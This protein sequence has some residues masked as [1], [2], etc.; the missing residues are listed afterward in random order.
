[1]S[2]EQRVTT[3]FAGLDKI[4][5]SLRIGDNVVW[6]TESVNDYQYFVTPFVHHALANNRQIVYMRFGQH[7]PL[8][9]E[10]APITVHQLDAYRGFEPF[11]TRVHNIITETGPGAFYVFDC[12]S[13]LLLAW[14][15]DAMISNFFQVTCP[16]LFELDTIAYFALI[17]SG[18]SF[19]TIA[20]I[21]QT[22]QLLLDIY[23][24]NGQNYVHPMKVWQRH[25][26]T[27]FLPHLEQDADFVPIANSY[28]ATNLT[29]IYL[30]FAHNARRQLDYW[31]RLFLEA[32]QLVNN[33]SPQQM[34]LRMIDQLCRVMI[35]HD[36]RMLDL[37]RQY[38]S[39][40]DLLDIKSRTIGTGYIG[41]K[42]VGMLLAR[43]ILLQD[44]DFDWQHYFEPH[45]SFF[46]ASDTYFSYIVHNG[47]WKLL[48]RQK[49]TKGY[50][51]IANELQ[52]KLRQGIFPPEVQAK[53]QEMLEH[54][55]QYP[56]IVRSSSLQEDSFGNAFAGKYES[57]FCVNQG[58]PEE[59]YEQFENAV[60]EIYA[61]T[62]SEDALTYRRQRGLDQHQEQMALLV[63]RVSGAY[64]DHYYFPE[65]AGVGVSHNTFVWDKDMDPKAGM[66][67]LVFGLGTRAVDRVEGDYPRIVA[68]DNPLKQPHH[69]FDDL[70]RFSQRDVDLL[71]VNHNTL[72]TMSLLNL[73]NH[74]LNLDME[75]YAVRDHDLTQ[76]LKKRGDKDQVAWLLTF[77]KLFTE[78]HFTEIMQ[79]MLKTLEKTYCY[80]VDIEFTV[81]FSDGETPK[82]N[83]LQCRPLQTRGQERAVQIPED[84]EAE[85]I[86]FSSQGHFMGGNVSQSIQYLIWVDPQE[87]SVLPR[88]DKYEVARLVGHLNKR[89]CNK[90]NNP[91]LL[92]GPGRWG[93]STPSLGIPVRFA[94]INNVTAL[95]EI[96]F[97][98]E[99][100][101]P[102]LSFGTHFFQDLVETEIFYLALFPENPCCQINSDF[103][104]RQ[105]N[106]LKELIPT[107]S[108]FNKVIKVMQLEQELYLMSDVVSQR[109]ICFH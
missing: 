45:D 27:M 58:T 2:L 74:C 54:F 52:E 31:D 73:G 92:M 20:Q 70:R 36:D 99:G 95:V 32:E 7:K 12:L 34:Q 85:R 90:Q 41:G 14:A 75:R 8:I 13:D 9:D 66:L 94:E 5:D 68:L 46:I 48:M 24:C 62:M 93:T 98:S 102:E 11:A 28:D 87:Y 77:E 76:Q 38:F 18:H 78:T 69:G 37:A 109:V 21:R 88:S 42:T 96:A 107:S 19:Q 40:E 43:N 103:L 80:P 104:N 49:T 53:F 106:L 47:W 25:S 1:M 10:S 86:F 71:D 61:S 83:L 15:T 30:G 63:Q 51:S 97:T 23:T 56:I 26:P 60:R 35:G 100:L 4:L 29:N 105:R 79:R 16:Y 3:G 67:R 82:I 50:F 65:L 39:L 101:M 89:H 91:T 44:F 72:K 81:N 22:T 57:F 108:R 6:R 33:P 55:G 64:H 84:L 59:R 17:R